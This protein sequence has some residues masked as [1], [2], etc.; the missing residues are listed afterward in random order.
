MR[1]FNQVTETFSV[2]DLAEKIRQVGNKLGY[3]V[4]I[5]HMENPRKEKEEHYYNPNYTGLIDLGLKPH[6]LTDEVL[7]EMFSQAEKHKH[8]IQENK[9][10]RG[11]RW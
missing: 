3:N 7:E 6:Y 4:K 10:F 11:I 8:N 1:I 2:N 5:D 9:I